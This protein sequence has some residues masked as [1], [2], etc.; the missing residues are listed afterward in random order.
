MKTVLFLRHAKSSWEYEVADRDRPLQPKGMK[1][2]AAVAQ[3]YKS[4]FFSFD[5]ILSSPANR[6]MHTAAILAH[7]IGFSFSK[8]QLSEALY[9]FN[10]TQ[11]I[12]QVHQLQEQWSKIILVGHNPAFSYAADYFSVKPAPELKTADWISLTF[13]QD[14]WSDLAKGDLIYGSKNEAQKKW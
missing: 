5:Y 8:V 9:T 13:A 10:G 14:K 1:A 3:H 4:T 2:I 11:I 6:A 12:E 7:E